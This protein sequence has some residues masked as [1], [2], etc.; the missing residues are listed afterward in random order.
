MY[1]HLPSFSHFFL[2][3]K[4]LLKL[5]A[6]CFQT[7]IPDESWGL[8]R[9]RPVSGM[10]VLPASHHSSGRP[11]F[12]CTGILSIQMC[13]KPAWQPFYAI[14]VTGHCPLHQKGPRDLWNPQSAEPGL[15]CNGIHLVRD[16]N[17][18]DSQVGRFG[19]FVKGKR[20]VREGGCWEGVKFRYDLNKI[21]FKENV[22]PLTATPTKAAQ[23]K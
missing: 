9:D 22:L 19:I 2:Q 13:S 11:A 3:C 8:K 16:T 23:S 12:D 20:G 21:G 18:L 6:L 14:H 10:S 1:P 5:L 15:N 17:R 4:K 7:L